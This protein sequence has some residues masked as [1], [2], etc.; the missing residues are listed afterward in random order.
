[1]GSAVYGVP[2]AALAGVVI[3]PVDRNLM[4]PTSGIVLSLGRLPTDSIGSFL[5]NLNNVIV[6]SRIRVEVTSSGD[7]IYDGD[8]AATTVNLTLPAYAP[9]STNNSLTVKVRKASVSPFY[10]PYS[11]QT[12]AR[13]GS[14]DLYIEQQ[15]DE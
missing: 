13:V 3:S 12:V 1:M 7:T 10:K 5:L 6:G 8:A 2:D 14:A 15:L 11:T 4:K 9:G